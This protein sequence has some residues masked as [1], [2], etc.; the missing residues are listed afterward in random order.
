MP[1]Q[2]RI[3]T[4][5]RDQLHQFAREWK[6]KVVPLREE[7][8]FKIGAS[9]TIEETNQFVWIVSYEG[10]EDWD[11]KEKKYYSSVKRKSIRPNPSRLIARTV[12][13]NVEKYQ[14]R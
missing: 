2:L 7:H 4:I 11:A 14:F 5:N 6:D 12:R 8:G 3:Y 13:H 9:C 1:T 10:D